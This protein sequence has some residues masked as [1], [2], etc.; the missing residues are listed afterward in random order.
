MLAERLASQLLSG[1]PARDG[2][3]VAERMLAI[4]AQ[5]LRGARLAVRART[6]GTSA[7]DLDRALSDERSLIV[8]W[9]NRGTLHMIRHE[10]YF[11]LHALTAPPTLPGVRRRLGQEQV[12]PD[13]AERAVDA[14]TRA[15]ADDGPLTRDELRKRIAAAGVR[16]EGQALVHLLALASLRGLTVRGP[17][18]GREQAFVL[19]RD[20]LGRSPAIDRGTALRELARRYLAGHQPASDR[21]LARWAG[22]PLRDAR[23]GLGAIADQIRTREDGLLEFRRSIAPPPPPPPRLLGPFEPCLLGWASRETVLGGHADLITRNG[24]FRPFAMVDGRAAAAWTMPGGKV[25]LEPFAPLR[26]TVVRAL[27]AD[28]ADVRRF[29][30]ERPPAG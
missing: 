25:R 3:A 10:D 13:A 1:P 27:E 29:L 30:A 16:T 23:A 18:R 24:M 7:A 4:Q 28:A 19:V 8:S 26:A 14:I 12:S 15:L 21:D 20:W 9:L 22:L 6:A 17:M 2:V 11:W 5:D